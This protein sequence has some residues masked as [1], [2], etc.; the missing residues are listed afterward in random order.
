MLRVSGYGQRT[1]MAL[2]PG[3]DLNYIAVSGIL[4]KINRDP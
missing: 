4:S 3:H 1:Q 2:K